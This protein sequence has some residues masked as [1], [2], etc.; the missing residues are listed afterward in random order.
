VPT[1]RLPLLWIGFPAASPLVSD[2]V[3]FMIQ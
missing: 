2:T 3:D 1:P